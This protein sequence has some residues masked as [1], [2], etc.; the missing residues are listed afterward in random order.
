MSRLVVFGQTTLAQELGELA[1]ELQLDA[2]LVALGTPPD[3]LTLAW[4]GLPI[5]EK[6]PDTPGLHDL[7]SGTE[8]IILCARTDPQ[9]LDL[10]LLLHDMNPSLRIVISLSHPNLAREIEHLIQDSTGWCVAL[11]PKEV[12][13]P[14]FA[15]SALENNVVTAFEH[16]RQF[17][18]VIHGQS[19][20]GLELAPGES[21][22]QA[23]K[24]SELQV[25]REELQGAA[26]NILA[27]AR[28]TPDL[29]LTAIVILVAVVL[30]SAA[31]FFHFHE[32]LS[33]MSSAYFVVT[34]FC[35]VGYGDISLKD[36]DTLSK[37]VGIVLMFSSMFLTASL[38]A[39]LTNALV[40]MRTN[41]LEGR[42]RFRLRNHVIVCGYGSLGAQVVRILRQLRIKVLVIENQREAGTDEGLNAQQVPVMIA[43][44]SQ[45]IVLERACL[46][47][48]RSMVCAMGHDLSAIEIAISARM[49][50]PN[51]RAVVRIWGDDFAARL[52]RHL[53]LHST[54]SV[55]N[56]AAPVFLAN[57]L[58]PRGRTLLRVAGTLQ[59]VVAVPAGRPQVGKILVEGKE[60]LH[61]VPMDALDE[62]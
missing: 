16:E 5:I 29:F 15:L 38:F 22:I 3:A 42:R 32:N 2:C 27:H 11:N 61:L 39:I 50:R 21:L 8:S 44:A 33:W 7:V 35:T 60:S 14:A 26:E 62:A 49:M 40:Q 55:A 30:T 46:R 18:A 37:I 19:R 53:R 23:Q 43:D 13:A 56:Q 51:L 57:A 34:T 59:A 58:H 9:N 25:S 41:R 12:S 4:T 24:L 31:A 52:K 54:L 28:H 45:E 6:L 47:R 20:H 36:S 17:H 48:A 1:R 10:A